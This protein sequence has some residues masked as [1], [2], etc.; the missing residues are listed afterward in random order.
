[1]VWLYEGDN[2]RQF[3]SIQFLI[4]CKIFNVVVVEFPCFACLQ[5]TLKLQLHEYCNDSFF[6][7][8]LQVNLP[9]F[10]IF[11]YPKQL[12][13]NKKTFINLSSKQKKILL[14]L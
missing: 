6:V 9:H 2:N 11:T 3:N 5:H 12:N 1:M 7:T 13:I 10:L 14:K 4:W 8:F